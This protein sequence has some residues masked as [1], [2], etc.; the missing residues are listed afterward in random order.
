MFLRN[1]LFLCFCVAVAVG[2]GL[3]VYHTHPYVVWGLLFL[4]WAC[5][6]LKLRADTLFGERAR[7][8]MTIAS[9]GHKGGEAHGPEA[10]S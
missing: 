3:Y 10:A 4:C 8:A 5:F 1:L 2:I 7:E 9:S 6:R